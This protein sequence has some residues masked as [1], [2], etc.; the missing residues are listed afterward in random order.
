M[1]TGVKSIHERL[2]LELMEHIS[3]GIYQP[4]DRLPS[5]RELSS[6]YRVN[7]NTITK[8]YANLEADGYVYS[9]PAKGYYV[10]RAENRQQDKT[11]EEVEKRGIFVDRIPQHYNSKC[12]AEEMGGFLNKSDKIL[13]PASELASTILEQKAKD[14]GVEMVRVTAYLNCMPTDETAKQYIK[15]EC[16]QTASNSYYRVWWNSSFSAT[17]CN[18]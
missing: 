15:R 2:T 18:I 12:A 5:V 1:L 9:I 3:L 4:E 8:V 16:R 10:A 6:Q 7:P 14:I 11:K 17:I 13:F